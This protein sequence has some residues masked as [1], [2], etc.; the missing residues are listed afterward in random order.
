MKG[1]YALPRTQEVFDILHEAEVLSTIDMKSGYHWVE[2]EGIHIEITAFAVDPLEFY[3]YRKMPFGLT[4]S[5]ATYQRL[6]KDCLCDYI[7]KNAS[8]TW[9]ILL[10]SPKIL[11]SI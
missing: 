7:R 5:P 8:F 11:K 3:E 1:A 2:M 4:N 6:L 10:F 9:T